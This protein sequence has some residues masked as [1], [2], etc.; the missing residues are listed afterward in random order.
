MFGFFGRSSSGVEISEDSSYKIPT[1]F[2][3]V[4]RISE[5][6]AMSPLHVYKY[7]KPRGQDKDRSHHLHR[8][9]HLKPN[10]F[11]TIYDFKLLMA[12]SQLTRGNAYALIVEN[13]SGETEQL[14]PMHPDRVLPFWV[15]PGEEKAYAYRD[16]KGKEHI[17][18]QSEVLHFMGPSKDGGLSGVA[19]IV[20]CAEAAG[21]YIAA[22]RYGAR[23]FANDSRPGGYLKSEKQL[24]GEVQERL[25][26]SWTARHSGANNAHKIAVLEDGLDFKEIGIPPE[27]AQFLETRKFQREE[28]AAIFGIPPHLVGILDKATF[29]NIEN[30]G[31]EY[32]TYTLMPYFTNWEK[33]LMFKLLTEREQITHFIKFNADA[34]IRADIK[35]R[36][37]AYNQGHN[38]GWLSPNDI[39][40]KEDMNP[41]PA[42]KGGDD[43]L[44]PENMRV[45]GAPP[46]Q[47]ADIDKKDTQDEE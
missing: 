34:Y 10:G 40:E 14:I 22:E 6:I 8:L 1:A 35:A 19:P 46:E 7:K 42:D 13:K 39:R 36:Y 25:I 9:F 21:I 30:Q 4:K 11:Q 27:Q 38:G 26:K 43:Y 15:K 18:L 16:H 45:A 44:Q 20:E 12:V 29:S 28:V 32:L 17:L 41:I 37:E 5:S 31:Q 47:P 2:A 3:A 23:F 33:A 24:N